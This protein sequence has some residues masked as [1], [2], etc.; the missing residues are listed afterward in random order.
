MDLV[1]RQRAGI[2]RG[3]LGLDLLIQ[4]DVG[5]ALDVNVELVLS[6]RRRHEF[7]LVLDH[8]GEIGDLVEANDLSLAGAQSHPPRFHFGEGKVGR[9]YQSGFLVFFE[10]VP[11]DV[12]LQGDQVSFVDLVVFVVVD[13]DAVVDFDVGYDFTAFEDVLFLFV[14]EVAEALLF[15]VGDLEV[16]GEVSRFAL[17]LGAGFGLRFGE[18]WQLHQGGVAYPESLRDVL[19]ELDAVHAGLHPFLVRADVD[20][21]V[22]EGGGVLQH[23]M[24]VVAQLV[25]ERG[26]FPEEMGVEQEVSFDED[27]VVDLGF[28]HAALQLQL[29]FLQGFHF[30][31][32][33]HV[34]LAKLCGSGEDFGQ[35]FDVGVFRERVMVPGVRVVHDHLLSELG[36]VIIIE[37]D[38]GRNDHHHDDQ[39]HQ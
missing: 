4:P 29:Q 3:E 22:D 30:L 17:A 35:Q 31:G 5:V 33:R 8:P 12:D 16:L 13:V 36:R 18:V 32:L 7:D 39:V 2:Q 6:R 26:G 20:H 34:A 10:V 1:L 23:E 27:P 24:Q 14:G 37:V 19:S 28:L 25:G 21:G 15:V 9:V 38:A 11:G